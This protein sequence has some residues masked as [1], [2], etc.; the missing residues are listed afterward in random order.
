MQKSDLFTNVYDTEKGWATMTMFVQ[1]SEIVLILITKKC[2]TQVIS[3]IMN[4]SF[5]L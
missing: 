5:S 2:W 1:K 4:K 3:N